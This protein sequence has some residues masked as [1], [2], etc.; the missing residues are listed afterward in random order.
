MEPERKPPKPVAAGSEGCIRKCKQSEITT[1]K[2]EAQEEEE[3]RTALLAELR[4]DLVLSKMDTLK[5]ERLGVALKNR[6]ISVRQC[7]ALQCGLLD[8]LFP[9]GL[10]DGE[11]TT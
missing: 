6:L 8:R 1:A 10:P 5:I 4:R 11:G 3:L 2:C 9:D 7:L